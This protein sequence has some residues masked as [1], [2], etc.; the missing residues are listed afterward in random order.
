[1]IL[2]GIVQLTIKSQGVPFGFLAICDTTACLVGNKG[3][4]FGSNTTYV[5]NVN[6][7]TRVKPQIYNARFMTSVSIFYKVVLTVPN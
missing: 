4:F 7:V 1:M 5:V 3:L 2:V 6:M